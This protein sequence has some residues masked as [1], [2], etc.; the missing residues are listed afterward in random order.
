MQRTCHSVSFLA[1]VH[2]F[3]WIETADEDF[4]ERNRLGN[5]DGQDNRHE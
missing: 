1:Q 5:Q 2:M 4:A 3:A